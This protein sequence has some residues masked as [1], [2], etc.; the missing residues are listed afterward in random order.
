MIAPRRY[1]S[2]K[3]AQRGLLLLLRHNTGKQCTAKAC[4][5]AVS[6]AFLL[7]PPALPILVKSAPYR[8]ARFR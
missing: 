8:S 5:A 7:R 3:P 4:L 6:I 1:R 2:H